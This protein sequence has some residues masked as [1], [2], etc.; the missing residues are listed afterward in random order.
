MV[1]LHAGAGDLKWVIP[2]GWGDVW[3]PLVDTAV[4]GGPAGGHQYAPRG[5]V[6][7]VGR[8]LVLLKRGTA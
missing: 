8:S 7:V 2:S 5:A 3:T 1:L 6:P 4:P